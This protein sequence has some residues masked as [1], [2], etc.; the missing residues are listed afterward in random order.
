MTTIRV[1]TDTALQAIKK[2]VDSAG[3]EHFTTVEIARVMGADE[4][5]VRIAFSWLTRFKAIERVPG[6]RSVRY[7]ETQGEKYSA[8]VYRIREEAAPVDFAALNR[9]FGYGC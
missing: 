6:V 8:S 4:Y 1:T 5:H 3:K 7:T 9:L 2:H